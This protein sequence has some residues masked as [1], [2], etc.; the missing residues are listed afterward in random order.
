MLAQVRFA[1]T[2]N[3]KPIR[4]PAAGTVHQPSKWL[5]TPPGHVIND[6]NI[7]EALKHQAN[8]L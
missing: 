6:A 1:L 2:G 8:V 7:R 5:S 4:F 3:R